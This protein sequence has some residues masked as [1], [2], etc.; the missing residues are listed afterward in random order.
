MI[1]VC[2]CGQKSRVRD[3]TKAHLLRCGGCKQMLQAEIQRQANRNAAI[4]LDLAAVVLDRVNKNTITE[5]ETIIAGIMSRHE[6][7]SLK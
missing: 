6:T 5:P 7:E 2:S 1:V 3:V 4:V